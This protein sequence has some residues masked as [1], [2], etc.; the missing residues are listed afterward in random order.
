MS[1]RIAR[2]LE[3]ATQV[4]T[5]QRDALPAKYR[6]DIRDEWRKLEQALDDAPD[7]ATALE[8]IGD[9][10]RECMA[11]VSEVVADL[12]ELRAMEQDRLEEERQEPKTPPTPPA[13][14]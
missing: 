7:E 10:E 3:R 11:R 5:E 4:V 1:D 8:A 2:E 13:E 9:Y 6:P 12:F 14:S